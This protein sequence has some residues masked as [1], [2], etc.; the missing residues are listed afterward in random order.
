M[1]GGMTKI[2]AVALAG[3][4]LFTSTASAL[5][6]SATSEIRRGATI[7]R[8]QELDNKQ[9]L[10]QRIRATHEEY[11][12]LR[13][14]NDPRAEQVGRELESLKSQWTSLYG[15]DTEMRKRGEGKKNG[16]HKQMKEMKQKRQKHQR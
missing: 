16:H 13:N 5:Q 8:Q 2:G 15:N 1:E 7:E 10:R 6:T 14:A 4:F 12:A 9:A 3:A 11:R